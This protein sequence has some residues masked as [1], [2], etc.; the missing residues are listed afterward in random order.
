MIAQTR[1]YTSTE[2]DA[3]TRL[4]E[5][6]DK[7]FELIGGE[8]FEAPS[9]PY[10]SALAATII[11][12]L[13]LFIRENQIEGHVTGE[14]GGYW[15]NGERYTP[16]VAYISKVKQPELAREGYNPNP[17]DLAVEILSPTND[18]DKLR[19]KI[20]N[21]LLAGVLVWVV[22]PQTRQVEVY[23]PGVAPRIL[24]STGLLDG[25]TVLPGFRLA[26]RDIFE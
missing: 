23:K 14:A 19:I 5:N 16:D 2:F 11:F 3:L 6:A 10:V 22:N 25:D 21:Y 26:V 7:L 9:N 15:V 13:K 18:D 12:F 20:T 1:F 8:I 24:D 4:P 17:P